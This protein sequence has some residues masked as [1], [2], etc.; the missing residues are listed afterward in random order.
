MTSLETT[1]A[2]RPADFMAVT[3]R[4]AAKERPCALCGKPILVGERYRR[5][6]AANSGKFATASS[7]ERCPQISANR[8]VPPPPPPRRKPFNW[9]ALLIGL[10]A[11]LL[12]LAYAAAIFWGAR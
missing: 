4:T 5:A 1:R 3:Y 2:K 9:T 11:S 10:G 12:A 8:Y 6:T 7:H